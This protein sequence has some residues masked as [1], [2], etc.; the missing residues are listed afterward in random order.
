[1]TV[2]SRMAHATPASFAA[3]IHDR[4]LESEIADQY[5]ANANLDFSLGGGKRHFIDAFLAKLKPA[6]YTI[7]LDKTELEAYRAANE[8]KGTLRMF[9]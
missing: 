1:M 2:T 6:G 7:T 5:C 8:A 9:G 4:D 3:H